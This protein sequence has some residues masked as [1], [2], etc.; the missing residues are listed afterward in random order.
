[1]IKLNLLVVSFKFCLVP[2]K[3]ILLLFEADQNTCI[4]L[5]ESDKAT[6]KLCRLPSMETGALQTPYLEEGIHLV[7][8]AAARSAS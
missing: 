4:Q 2:K 5:L 8:E 7:P 3:L 1:M 6:S